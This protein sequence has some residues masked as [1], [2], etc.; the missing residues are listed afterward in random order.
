MVARRKAD[1]VRR[2]Q[3]AQAARQGGTLAPEGEL[4]LIHKLL[5]NN[6]IRTT[7]RYTPVADK[8]VKGMGNPLDAIM[9][10]N[11]H[12]SNSAI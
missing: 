4:N 8:Q 5:G 12:A 10:K 3:A 2:N 7:L 1:T 11:S 9:R 6:D